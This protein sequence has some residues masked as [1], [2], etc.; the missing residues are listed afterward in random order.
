MMAQDLQWLFDSIDTAVQQNSYIGMWRLFYDGRQCRQCALK[1]G[2]LSGAFV[3][4]FIVD[5]RHYVQSHVLSKTHG[6][7]TC[8]HQHAANADAFNELSTEHYAVITL[9]VISMCL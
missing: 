2:K 5:S 4:P 1:R 6:E 8:A 9:Y 7:L 3:A